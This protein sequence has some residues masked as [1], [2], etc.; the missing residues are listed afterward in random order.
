MALTVSVPTDDLGIRP[1]G[2]EWE[3]TRLVDFD[4]SY[5]LGGETL[6]KE[7]LGF[8]IAP[9][10]VTIENRAGY[11]FRYDRTNELLI[12]ETE[13]LGVAQATLTI[14]DDDNA[15]T[16]G[17]AVYLHID[18]VFEQGNFGF[19]HLE[20]V[21]AGNADSYAQTGNG[22][23]VSVRIQ[24]DDNAATGGVALYFDEDGVN[25][26]G[27]LVADLDLVGSAAAGDKIIYVL[28]SDG[29]YLGVRDLETATSVGVQVFFDDDAANDYERLKFV[30]PT[31]ADGSTRL[32]TYGGEV[33]NG[34]DLSALTDVRVTARGKYLK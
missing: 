29:T 12:A 30:S 31:N 21:N 28:L 2:D 17:V 4:S 23:G 25:G 3:L 26:S 33:P 27:R 22:T 10:W 24:D 13:K 32:W 20:A 19:G 8:R 1:V 16:A 18:E 9:R 15:A 34:T 14:D 11:K 5:A 7:N 6:T